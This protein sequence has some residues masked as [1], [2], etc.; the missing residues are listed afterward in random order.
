MEAVG[1]RGRR[2]RRDEQRGHGIAPERVATMPQHDEDEPATDRPTDT[3]SSA[4]VPGVWAYGFTS[5]DTT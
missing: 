1:G 4:L 3:R 2:D 5:P